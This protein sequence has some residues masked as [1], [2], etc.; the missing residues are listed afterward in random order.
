MYHRFPGSYTLS[1]MWEAVRPKPRPP[2]AAM[3]HTTP[4]VETGS[5]V[6]RCLNLGC[7]NDYMP[8]TSERVWVNADIATT[9]KADVY[10][11]AFELPWPLQDNEFDLV[12]AYDFLEHVPHTVFDK[13]R[14]AVK[15]DGFIVVMDELWRI[16]KPGGVLEARFP[17]FQ[18]KNNYIDPT[19]TRQVVKPTFEFYFEKGGSHAFYT[20]RYWKL[21]DFDISQRD[22][23]Y[24]RLRKVL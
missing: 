14:R 2:R 5:A 7:G 15:G 12:K 19:H 9:V 16:L 18:H 13:D 24:A 23:H 3:A 6:W 21:L 11:D 10:F 8:S 22:N 20:T 4:P 1:R 17:A